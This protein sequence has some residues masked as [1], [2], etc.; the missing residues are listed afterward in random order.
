M[1]ISKIPKKLIPTQVL[2][3]RVSEIAKAINRD[4]VGKEL[5]VIGIL[6]GSF[7]FMADLIRQLKVPVTCDFMTLASYGNSTN[8]KGVCLN[9][10]TIHPVKGKNILIIEDI[11]DTGS[12]AKYFINRLWQKKPKSVAVCT[13]LRK[14]RDRHHFFKVDYLGFAI[15]DKFV[16][17][18]GLDYKGKYRN[19]PYIATVK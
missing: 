5:T 16:A 3:K 9:L 7:I 14:N 2:Q 19:L 12:T 8:S 11:I 6:N 13:L 4:Y 18:Y 1:P 17:G 10:D 15:P